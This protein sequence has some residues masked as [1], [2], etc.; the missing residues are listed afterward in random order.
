MYKP[1]QFKEFSVADDRCIMKTGTDGV[2]LGASVK[3]DSAENILDI[4]TGSGLIA[5][6]IAQ[7]SNAHIDAVELDKDSAEQ[8]SENF[9]TSKWSERLEVFH[10]SIQK[11][12]SA[13]E[14]KYDVI[15]CNPPFFSNSLKSSIHKKKNRA[16]HNDELPFDELMSSAKKLMKEDASFW[17]IIPDQESFMLESLALEAG[18]FLNFELEIFSKEGKAV[19]RKIMK[20]TTIEYSKEKEKL[21]IR[22]ADHSFTSEYIELTNKFY[23]NF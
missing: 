17:L 3:L 18:L 8:A 10:D 20:F 19:N 2:L 4:G 14:K 15:V 13:S 6:M 5:L 22:N 23:L 21:T 11:Y 9:K 12:A 7:R 16:R 1:F